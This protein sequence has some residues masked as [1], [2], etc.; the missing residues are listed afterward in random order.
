MSL[1]SSLGEGPT[2]NTVTEPQKIFHA[3]PKK[4]AKYEYLRDVQGEVLS[5]WHVRRAEP[6]TVLKMNTGGGKTVVGLL[7]L[8][9]C[10]NE[11][12]GPAAYMAPDNYLCD[13]VIS[14]ARELGIETTTDPRSPHYLSGRAILVIPVHTLFN[15]R[16]KFGV[17]AEG[18]KLEIGSIVVDDAHA[19]LSIAEQKF[20]LSIP[21]AHPAYGQLF[22]IFKADLTQQSQT[23]TAELEQSD[24]RAFP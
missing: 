12:H 23:S 13:Q 24:P 7:A 3:L 2:V 18:V 5:Q 15:G 1:F 20:T 10:L 6:D 14:E 8:K 17:G 9:S 16:S 22:A 4:A 11:G 21:R 19:C